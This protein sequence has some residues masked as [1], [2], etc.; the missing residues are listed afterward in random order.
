M[1][2]LLVRAPW[3]AV[4]QDSILQADFQ[5]AFPGWRAGSNRPIENRPPGWNPAPQWA[6][7]VALAIT[8]TAAG[9]SPKPL[10][11]A[12]A[13]ATALKNHPRINSALL[14]ARAT[15]AVTKQISAAR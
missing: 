3:P 8:A 7:V 12:E 13:E 5:S 9:Q 11:L 15:A 2:D 14:N 4:G 6:A 1:T 10:T